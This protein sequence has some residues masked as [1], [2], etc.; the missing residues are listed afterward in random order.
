MP[1]S[2]RTRPDGGYAQRRCPCGP[3]TIQLAITPRP[4]P[5]ATPD[6]RSG[7]RAVL[8]NPLTLLRLGAPSFVHTAPARPASPSADASIHWTPLVDSHH[9]HEHPARPRYAT[10][11]RAATTSRRD[12]SS[13]VTRTLARRA[14]RDVRSDTS[15]GLER[16]R[17]SRR[18]CLSRAG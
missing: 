2:T 1:G 8:A 3:A 18:R 10:R 9:P 4:S 13:D 5:H 16:P 14:S 6:G 17:T 7:T 15:S 12:S 11:S